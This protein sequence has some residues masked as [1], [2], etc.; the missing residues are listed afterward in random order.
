VGKTDYSQKRDALRD[1]CPVKAAIDVI[2]GRWK[3]LIL[4]ELREG[5]KRLRN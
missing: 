4:F 3:P 1:H 2:R 5:K